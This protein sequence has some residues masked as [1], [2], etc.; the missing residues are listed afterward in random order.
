MK[1]K[2]GFSIL[3]LIVVISILALI[4]AIAVPKLFDFKSGAI[5][6]TIKQ[7]VNTISNAI[8]SYYTLEGGID[9]ISDAVK[10]NEQYW[11]GTGKKLEFSHEEKVCVT[12]EV[13]I[14]KLSIKID[15]T[16]SE[17]CQ[18]IYDKGVRSISYDLF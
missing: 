11:K 9:N 10:V 7:D 13:E 15:Q 8:Q 12:I 5:V 17:L 4:S 6:S 18:E 14:G 3:E 1:Q 16:S 2:K